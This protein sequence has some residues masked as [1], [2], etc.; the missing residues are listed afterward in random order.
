MYCQVKQAVLAALDCGYRHIDCA[1]VYG[2][3]Q[4]VGDALALR[5]G[6]GKVRSCDFF[7]LL[8]F[9]SILLALFNVCL[10]NCHDSLNHLSK[11]KRV[12]LFLSVKRVLD[13][14]S[15]STMLPKLSLALG[16]KN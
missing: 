9:I 15:Q 11:W 2:N 3:E 8:Y 1:A 10:F 14:A 6:P 12:S 7:F 4:E 16:S 5:V 13:I